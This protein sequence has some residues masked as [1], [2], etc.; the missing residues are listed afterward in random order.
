MRMQKAELWYSH[1]IMLCMHVCVYR[2]NMNR[3]VHRRTASTTASTCNFEHILCTY[4]RKAHERWFH[5]K[6]WHCTG[7]HSSLLLL[8]MFS[9]SCYAYVL[10]IL[11]RACGCAYASHTAWCCCRT[12]SRSTCICVTPVAAVLR[13]ACV[14]VWIAVCSATYIDAGYVHAD[15][16]YT[17]FT[18]W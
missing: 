18:S 13:L 3:I 17:P 7:E 1:T 6:M 5:A 16:D 8:V 14:A 11:Q 10:A 2:C 4:T 9:W 15:R 12:W